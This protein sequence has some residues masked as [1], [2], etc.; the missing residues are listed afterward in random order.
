M[1]KLLR[2]IQ[3]T[4]YFVPFT[5]YLVAFMAVVLPG[6]FKLRS[7]GRL[8][9]SAYTHV[10]SLL[11]SVAL[12][13]CASLLLFGL[14]TVAGSFLYFKWK[15]SRH[16]LQLKLQTAPGGNGGGQLVSLDMQPVLLPLAGFIRIRLFYDGHQVSEKITPVDSR[17]SFFKQNFKGHFRWNLP[18]LRE[19][20]IEKVLVYFEDY[21]QFFSMAATI[22]TSNRFYVGPETTDLRTLQAAPRKT[23]ESNVRIEELK[24]VEGEL[25]HY[26]SFEA[27][28]D[29]RRIVW[30]I[31]ARNKEL[32]VRVPEILDPY[33]SHIYLYTS[34]YSALSIGSN[35]VI[36]TSFLNYYKTQCWSVYEQLS[37]KGFE[38]RY[39]A[40]QPLPAA[41]L[42]TVEDQVHYGITVS[43][44]QQDTNL[45]D[46]VKPSQ[47]SVLVVSSLSDPQQLREFAETHGND[48]SIIFI[49]LSHI[50]DE[51]GFTAWIEWLFIKKEQDLEAKQKTQWNLSPIRYQLKENEKEI[52]SIVKSTSKATIL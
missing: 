32:V 33:A 44:W 35:S 30:K 5:M 22:D 52:L 49:P 14:L 34:F 11:L 15:Q 48:V 36:H 43:K 2:S 46:L 19:Y 39:L 38:L 17:S 7:L 50:F 8:P 12:F 1:R 13:F 18:E 9:D 26:K 41:D 27:N 4:G 28:D 25:I 10:F 21:F 20:R 23:E 40:D 24:R 42:A 37:R 29:V 16:E 51:R 6:Y 31:Y 47:A 45:K 3:K